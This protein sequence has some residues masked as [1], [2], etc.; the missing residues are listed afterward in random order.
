MYH[1]RTV[2]SRRLVLA[3]VLALVATACADDVEVTFENE[4][5]LCVHP[6]GTERDPSACPEIAFVADDVLRLSV[7]FQRCLSSS[8][9]RDPR[10]SC[11]ATVDGNVI[12]VTAKGSYTHEEG[13]CTD[14]CGSL[15]ASCE[16]GPL[17][18]G[19]YELRYAGE[20]LALSLP[21]RRF[22]VCTPGDFSGCCDGDADCEQGTCGKT[23]YC[24]VP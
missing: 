6:E 14:D 7:N 22:D 20:T 8:C 12:T 4:G 21:S 16:V 17:P 1:S 13:E 24:G 10:A 19:D 5:S 15:V 3:S 18:A 11:E 23:H 2:V 9:D